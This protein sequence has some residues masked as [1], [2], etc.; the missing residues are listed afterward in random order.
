MAIFGLAE[1][2]IYY[3]MFGHKDFSL[4]ELA[5]NSKAEPDVPVGVS[6]VVPVKLRRTSVILVAVVAT[7][8]EEVGLYRIRGVGPD[9]VHVR[10]IGLTCTRT[11]GSCRYRPI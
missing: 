5:V 6:R 4:E 11:S 2:C 1:D 7:T 9:G 3:G 8:V 10:V